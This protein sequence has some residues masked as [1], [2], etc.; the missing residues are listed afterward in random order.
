[1]GPGLGPRGPQGR[2]W[3]WARDR[4]PEPGNVAGPKKVQKIVG[5][6]EFLMK[7]DDS[8]TVLEGQNAQLR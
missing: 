8:T 3:A 7:N 1:M 4:G 6:L 5:K 2:G